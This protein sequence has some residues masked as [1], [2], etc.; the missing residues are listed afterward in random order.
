MEPAIP[1]PPPR[2]LAWPN[3]MN[4]VRDAVLDQGGNELQVLDLAALFNE[5]YLR[6]RPIP[7]SRSHL[8][9]PANPLPRNYRFWWRFHASRLLGWTE[10]RDEGDANG[11]QETLNVFLRKHWADPAPPQASPF[12]CFK[13]MHWLQ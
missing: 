2:L 7:A 12:I 1:P 8:E 3:G 13:Y 6:A 4:I 9:W 10:R 5:A 11:Y